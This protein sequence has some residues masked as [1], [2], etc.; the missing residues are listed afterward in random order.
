MPF[1]N[2]KGGK[3]LI[4]D[5]KNMPYSVLMSV[6]EKES[7][8]NL[9]TSVESI[10]AQTVLP[11][12]FVLVIDGPVGI[13]LENEICALKQKY[14]LKCV[15][16]KENVGLAR[17]LN[18]GLEECECEIVARMDSDDI[19]LPDRM[20]KQLKLLSDA[21][22][23]IVS[24][25]VSEFE[26]DPEIINGK[27]IVPAT[28]NEILQFARKRTPFNHPAT[29]Y[30]KSLV[31][32]CGG[33]LNYEF[34]E[35][36]ELFARLLS[37]G[38]VGA[39]CEESLVLMRTGQGLFTRRGGVHYAKCVNSFYKRMRELGLCSAKEIFSVQ[40]P[41]VIVALIPNK[42]RKIVYQKFL[43]G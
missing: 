42:V 40:I 7:A 28:H 39:N 5:N 37:Q 30:K 19:S 23:D 13:E 14:S 32:K 29:V 10:F 16:I 15:Y 18:F 21:K 34:F 33:Y 17:A 27:R 8:Q 24:S 3:S 1:Y 4:M 12:D 9:K 2:R 36:Y 22:A 41:R 38:A 43:R 26:N 31:L 11:Q 25:A 6:Y 35:D 20:E